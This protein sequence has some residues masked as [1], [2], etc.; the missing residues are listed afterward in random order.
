MSIEK[1]F[2]LESIGASS[3]KKTLRDKF[4]FYRKCFYEPSFCLRTEKLFEKVGIN[5]VLSGNIEPKI[6]NKV[7]NR[8]VHSISAIQPT[9]IRDSICVQMYDD[10]DDDLIW[11]YQNGAF[12]LITDHNINGLPCFVTESPI[13]IYAKLC[14]YYRDLRNISVTAVTGS[15]GKTTLKR[16]IQSVYETELKTF[17]NVV[18]HNVLYHAGYFCQHIPKN[19]EVMI[20]EVS[21]DTPLYTKPMSIVLRPRIVA[22]TNITVAHIEAFGSYES[23]VNEVLSITDDM[24]QDGY[25][26]VNMDEFNWFE[27]LNDKKVIKISSHNTSADYCADSITIATDGLHFNV[28]C[29]IEQECVS[30]HLKNIFGLHNVSLALQAFAAGRLENLSIS[31]IVKGLNEFKMTGMR[32][33]YFTSFNGIHVYADCFN[34]VS[35]SISSAL[36]AVGN[37]PIKG[38]KVA[39]LGDVGEL[40]EF[41]DSEHIEIAHLLNEAECITDAIIYGNKLSNACKV[42]QFRN[43]LKLYFCTNHSEIISNLD[44]ILTIGDLVLFK[45]SHSCN[46]RD[47][48][49]KMWPIEYSQIN[50]EERSPYDKWISMVNRN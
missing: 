8:I 15:I 44:N 31:S 7:K 34:A 49:N 2:T 42:I 13:L 24:E 35:K 12:L 10:T 21:E 46:L 38:K 19:Y 22:I 18:N 29:K 45:G 14:R 39:V 30:I 17:C 9:F 37:I 27:L 41:S 6:W 25:I 48:I 11:A 5:P 1:N 26:I 43:N 4:F 47:V 16:M 28:I 36:N 20:Q 3:I 32:Q 50:H 40:G 33:N 23:I